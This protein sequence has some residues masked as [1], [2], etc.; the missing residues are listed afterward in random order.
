VS[1]PDP[2]GA[3]ASAPASRLGATSSRRRHIVVWPMLMQFVMV[4]ATAAVFYGL[5]RLTDATV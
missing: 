2:T 5:I 4:A 1:S 3:V